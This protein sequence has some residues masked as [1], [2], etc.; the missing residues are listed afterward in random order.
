MANARSGT[1]QGSSKLRCYDEAPAFLRQNPFIR[2]GYRAGYT[3]LECLRSVFEWNNETLNIWTHLSGILLFSA[4]LVH[5]VR[6]RLAAAGAS[7]I[8]ATVVVAFT[9]IYITTLSL[10]VLYHTFNCQ[11]KQVYQKLLK[12]DL[13]GVAMSLW[14][15]VSSGVV[16]AFDEH[17]FSKFLYVAI[18][19]VLLV[20][21][22][23]KAGTEDTGIFC[24]LGAFG[25]LPTI[26]WLFL[27]PP[28]LTRVLPWLVLLFLSSGFSYLVL[29]GRCPERLRPGYYDYVGSSHQI[30]HILVV[31]ITM[32]W[33][34]TALVIINCKNGHC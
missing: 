16:M 30:W 34:E 12:Y 25:L 33:H 17:P 9:C 19:A 29:E 2:K 24:S 13:V 18:E 1:A 4:V 28:Y 23:W 15:T 5:D 10:S 11:S 14:A 31:F 26:H 27:A 20:G 6:H 32:L 22:L 3:P 8:D 21:I 7:P